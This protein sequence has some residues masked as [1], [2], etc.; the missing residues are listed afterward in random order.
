VHDIHRLLL[1]DDTES[2]GEADYADVIELWDDRGHNVV[3]GSN[4][5]PD[6]SDVPW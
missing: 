4:F 1:P 2:A 6:D 3:G 5:A